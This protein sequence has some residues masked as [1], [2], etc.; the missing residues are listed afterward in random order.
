MG[1]RSSA[2]YLP[3]VSGWVIAQVCHR[4]WC[5]TGRL[6]LPGPPSSK[7]NQLPLTMDSHPEGPSGCDNKPADDIVPGCYGIHAH[8]WQPD[9]VSLPHLPQR[10][11][12][13]TTLRQGSQRYAMRAKRDRGGPVIYFRAPTTRCHPGY[14]RQPDEWLL[15]L[16]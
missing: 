10:C 12:Q 1:I 14:S 16:L 15:A 5:W 7:Q 2:I 3:H 11:N 9:A 13:S 4:V 8:Q 6:A